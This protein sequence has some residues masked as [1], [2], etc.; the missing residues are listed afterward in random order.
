MAK[1]KLVNISGN[2]VTV[3]APKIKKI[4]PVGNQVLVERLKASEINPSS[5]LLSGSAQDEDSNQAYILALG[6][7]VSKEY[8]IKVGDRVFLQGSFVPAVALD[9]DIRQ[10]NL[11]YPDMIKAV[12]CED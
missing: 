12:L 11:I 5:I 7:Q 1:N 9:D 2:T 8:G 4:V 10:K 3:A 6:P